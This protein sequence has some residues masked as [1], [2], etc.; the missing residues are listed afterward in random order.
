MNKYKKIALFSLLTISTLLVSCDKE[1]KGTGNSTLKATSDVTATVAVPFTGVQNVNESAAPSYNFTITL[2]KPQVVPVVIAIKQ[3]SGSATLGEDYK[4]PESL[5]IPAYATSVSGKVEIL[6]DD[7][8]EGTENFVLQIGDI[9]T[10]N[11][12]LAP[13]TMSFIINNFLS[14]NLDLTFNFDHKFTYAG[15]DYTLCQIGYD[16]DYYFLDANMNDTGV[17][18]AAASGCPEKITVTPTKLA[19]G[20]YHIFANVYADGGLSGAGISPAFGVETTVDY[21]RKGGIAPGSF[22]QEAGFRPTSNSGAGTANYYVITLQ[23]SGGVFT[24]K[25]SVPEVIASGRM[26]TKINDVIAAARLHKRK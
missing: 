12:K 8:V 13:K 18:D 3:I 9:T 1:D 21:V 25:N 22:V 19:D 16:M 6:N 24:L 17:Y 2:D 4:A 15:T 11:A 23:K 26:N 14:P 7:T 5:I 10:A 20:V